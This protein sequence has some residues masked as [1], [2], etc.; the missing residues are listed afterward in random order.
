[1]SAGAPAKRAAMAEKT[2]QTDKL[3]PSPVPLFQGKVEILEPSSK[4]PETIR[5]FLHR[6]Y[7][8]KGGESYA[9]RSRDEATGW[10]SQNIPVEVAAPLPSVRSI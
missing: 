10:S 6:R 5:Q 9:F 4:S 8:P 1:M 2:E 3:D 7:C